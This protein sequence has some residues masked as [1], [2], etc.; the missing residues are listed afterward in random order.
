MT[1]AK[2]HSIFLL[3]WQAGFHLH[4][5]IL[6]S[7]LGYLPIHANNDNKSLSTLHRENKALFTDYSVD[8]AEILFPSLQ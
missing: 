6:R 2:I 1:K 7:V 5:I 3:F 8:T 4:T